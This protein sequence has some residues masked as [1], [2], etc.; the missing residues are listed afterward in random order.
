MQITYLQ[1][2]FVR[3]FCNPDF[4]GQTRIYNNLQKLVRTVIQNQEMLQFYS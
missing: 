4:L 2:H 3:H 1:W